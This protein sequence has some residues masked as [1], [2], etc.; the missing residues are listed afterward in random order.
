MKRG[1]RRSAS[2][3]ALNSYLAAGAEYG[4][5]SVLAPYAHRREHR[6]KQERKSRRRKHG[7][8]VRVERRVESMFY[9]LLNYLRRI[10]LFLDEEED[11]D[12]VGRV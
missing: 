9:H 5:L 4:I 3:P 11:Q 8:D 1:A 12:S 2:R 6:G 10:R 7:E